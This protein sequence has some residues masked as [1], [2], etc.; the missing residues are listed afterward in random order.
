MNL[1]EG[2]SVK[3]T[4]AAKKIRRV[5]GYW[6]D[7]V[8]V[9]LAQKALET[10]QEQTLHHKQ[11]YIVAKPGYGVSPSAL[12]EEYKAKH[13][14]VKLVLYALAFTLPVEKGELVSPVWLEMKEEKESGL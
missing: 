8:F 10:G 6:N 11:W 2:L 3:Y 9:S 12:T 1:V 5:L 4:W 7:P 14:P 13:E